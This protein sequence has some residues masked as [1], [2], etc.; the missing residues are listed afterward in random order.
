MRSAISRASRA[1]EI[2]LWSV[3]AIAPSPRAFAVSSSSSAGV[4]QS[5]R[6]IGVHVQVAVDEVPALQARADSGVALRVVAA[7]HESPVGLLQAVGHL[8][9]GPALAPVPPRGGESRPQRLVAGEPSELGGERQRVP[10][11]E[12]QPALAVADQLAV[13]LEVRYHRHGPG[14]ERQAGRRGGDP[15]PAGGQ[16]HD[17]GSGDEGRRLPVAGPHQG[18]PLAQPPA[19]PRQRVRRPVEPDDGLPVELARKAAEGPEED[20]QRPPLL[21]RH[22][23]DPQPARRRGGQRRLRDV[24]AGA[25]Q[26]VGPAEEA[27]QHLPCRVVARGAGVYAAEEHVHQAARELRGDPLDGLVEAGDVE[28]DRVSQRGR[29]GARREGLVDVDDVEGH[30]PEKL[31]ERAAQVHRDRRRAPPR[32]ARQRDAPA[33]REHARPLAP[34]QVLG[35]LDRVADGPPRLPDLAPRVRRR[36]DDDPM[37]TLRERLGGPRHEAVY[38]VP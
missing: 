19:H 24:G 4:A 34:E 3:M 22:V 15:H 5:G 37:P 8:G 10:R 16:A 1:P 25:Q 18:E 27:L 38:L 26:L 33:D 21:R 35:V 32:P 28:R 31:L 29:P 9:P 36:C 13:D 12:Q 11:R 17:V 6:V 23:D 30:R 2:S 14:G 20:P 7:R